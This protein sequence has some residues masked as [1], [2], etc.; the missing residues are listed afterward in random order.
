[1]QLAL[2]RSVH[3][4]QPFLDCSRRVRLPAANRI[5]EEQLLLNA[6]RERLSRAECVVDLFIQ[7][8]SSDLPTARSVTTSIVRVLPS[9]N[10]GTL[11]VLQARHDN[12]AHSCDHRNPLGHA[13]RST[14]DAALPAA[15][16]R[17]GLYPG[18]HQ[19]TQS[20]RPSSRGGLS[21]V[22]RRSARDR[23]CLSSAI[24]FSR[25]L[26]ALVGLFDCHNDDG[27]VVLEWLTPA[28]GDGLLDGH[29]GRCG[30]GVLG[31]FERPFEALDAKQL[32]VLGSSFDDSVGYENEAFS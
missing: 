30:G 8:Q 5:H 17:R 15:I 22:L 16:R 10:R 27:G 24:R 1:M 32:A 14:A 21:R 9:W 2:D 18:E 3:R 12:P 4:T 7:T 23:R 11:V 6:E 31:A 20:A 19:S 26:A 29:G 13:S 25:T 28:V